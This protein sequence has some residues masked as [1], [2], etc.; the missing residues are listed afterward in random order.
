ML[1]FLS[2]VINSIVFSVIGVVM[3]WVSFVVIDTLTPYNLW[4]EISEDRNL[5]LAIVVGA[6]SLGICTIIAAAIHG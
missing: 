5:A 4:K 6:M 3:F 2:A 1:G